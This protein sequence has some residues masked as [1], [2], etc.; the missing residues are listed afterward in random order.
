[1]IEFSLKQFLE[2]LVS[3]TISH[4]KNFVEVF[5]H[6][7]EVDDNKNGSEADMSQIRHT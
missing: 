5:F 6:C 1:M 4:K 7:F 2:L 3:Y